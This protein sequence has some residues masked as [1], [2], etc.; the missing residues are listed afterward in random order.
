VRNAPAYDRQMADAEISRNFSPAALTLDLGWARI[1]LLPAA[2][3]TVCDQPPTHVLGLAFERQRGLHAVGGERRRDFDAWPGD[4]AYTAPGVEMFSESRQGGEYLTLR[5][6]GDALADPGS[7]PLPAGPPR[8]VFHGHRPALR[9]GWQLRRL[10]LAPAPRPAL[11]EAFAAQLLDSCE[12]LLGQSRRPPGA[13]AADRP[14]HARVLEHIDAAID[15]PLPLQDLA[16]LAQMPLLRFLRSFTGAVGCTPHA[17]IT[18][19]RLQRAR[20]LLSQSS[21]K[22]CISIA[23]IAADCGF[24]HQSHLGAALKA[25]L[26]MTPVQY[27]ARS[28]R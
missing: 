5:V 21:S 13:Y 22:G 25:R 20:A 19:R 24:A 16:A 27:R 11:I 23:A 2:P 7:A 28:S 14:R 15:T 8:T 9:L 12:A 3:Y 17:Y 18:E 10:M 6:A 4:L 26:G 1:A